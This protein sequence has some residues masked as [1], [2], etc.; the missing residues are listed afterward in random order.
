MHGFYLDGENWHCNAETT[1]P[2]TYLKGIEDLCSVELQVPDDIAGKI[3][4]IKP[5]R[6]VRN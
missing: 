4:E 5:E 6:M 2:R 3:I 1:D